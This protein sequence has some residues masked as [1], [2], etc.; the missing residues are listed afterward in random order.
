MIEQ[1]LKPELSVLTVF[2]YVVGL[3]LKKSKLADR[4]IPLALG[5]IGIF[6]ASFYMCVTEGFSGMSI[7]TGII[8]GVL[9]AATSV[10][11][12]QIVKQLGKDEKND[13][14]NSG[15]NK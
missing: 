1:Y 5:V 14:K 15:E 3:G 13:E 11:G 10:Y 6:V 9:Y 7:F 12:N 4:F 2:L 8:Q